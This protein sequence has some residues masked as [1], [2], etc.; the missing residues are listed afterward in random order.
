M[1]A[2]GSIP[3]PILKLMDVFCI[4]R[5]YA[6]FHVGNPASIRR[7][8]LELIGFRVT[9]HAAASTEYFIY[10]NN[11]KLITELL[12]RSVHFNP[13]KSSKVGIT[14]GSKIIVLYFYVLFQSVKKCNGA[15]T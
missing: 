10:F 11:N 3:L 8:H 13:H 7:V 5:V 14:V 1:F 6:H 2:S 12:P 15:K 4:F 9:T